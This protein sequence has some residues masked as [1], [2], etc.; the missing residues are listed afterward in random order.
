[1]NEAA[2]DQ[3]I[4]RYLENVGVNSHQAILR[5]VAEAREKGALAGNEM[6]PVRMTLE[7]PSLQLTMSFEGE[8]ELE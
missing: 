2:L 8:V 3:S 6:F 7:I 4:R 1:M 5:A